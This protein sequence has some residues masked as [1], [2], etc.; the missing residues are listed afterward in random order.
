V[1]VEGQDKQNRRLTAVYRFIRRS[2]HRQND[3]ALF[4][5]QTILP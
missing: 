4:M 3:F 5:P 2:I 1:Q